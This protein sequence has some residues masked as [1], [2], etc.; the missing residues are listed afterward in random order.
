VRVALHVVEARR[1]RMALLLQENGYLPVQEVCQRLGISEATARRDLAAL[2]LQKRVRRTFGGALV[3]LQ[4]RFPPFQ[5]RLRQGAE[6]KRRVARAA[7]EC[8]HEGYTC[9]MDPGTTIY[10]VAEALLETPV[11]PLTVVTASL[12]VANALVQMEGCQVH[13]LGGQLQPQQSA[14]LGPGAQRGVV[15]WKFDVALLGVQGVDAEGIWNTTAEVVDLQ[16]AVME[17]SKR[18]VICVDARKVG[19]K[20]PHFLGDWRG[21]FELLTPATPARLAEAGIRLDKGRLLRC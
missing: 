13:L 4:L 2:E 12:P 1:R 11:K 17:R 5:Q 3:D 6:G 9:Y 15:P 8:L 10:A 14:L 19:E 20:A 16:H 7:R 18:V 21:E